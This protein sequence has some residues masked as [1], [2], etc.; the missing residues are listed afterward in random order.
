MQYGHC[1]VRAT[2]TAHQL[3]VQAIN[4]TGFE[5]LFIKRPE[6]L[7]RIGCML[8][9]LLQA[10]EVLHIKHVGDSISVLCKAL[11]SVRGERI[12]LYVSGLRM[13]CF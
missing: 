10:G 13:R 11:P 8:I 1:V 7:H 3:L 5:R 4:S 2:D 12:G 9:E 6:G